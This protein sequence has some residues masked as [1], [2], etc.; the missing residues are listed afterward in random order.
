MRPLSLLA[1][2]L[3]GRDL[4]LEGWNAGLRAPCESRS[5]QGH[6][7]EV[8][9]LLRAALGTGILQGLAG[10]RVTVIYILSQVLFVASAMGGH[11]AVSGLPGPGGAVVQKAGKALG[12]DVTLTRGTSASA[13]KGM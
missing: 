6:P 10:F 2:L 3:L 13:C 9:G 4:A 12:K 5:W 11:W 1:I 8:A 7:R